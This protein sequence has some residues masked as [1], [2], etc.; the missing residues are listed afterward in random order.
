[1]VR[2]ECYHNKLLCSYNFQMAA[3]SSEQETLGVQYT[4]LHTQ[5]LLIHGRNYALD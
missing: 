2:I 3:E 1:M 5:M 4:L